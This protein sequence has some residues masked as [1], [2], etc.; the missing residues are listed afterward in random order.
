MSYNRFAYIYDML[1]NH[2]PYE[3]WVNFTNALI[4]QSNKEIK[5]IVD[6]GCGTGE[7]AIRLSDLGYDVTGVD[8][9]TEMLTAAAQK[10]LNR[11]KKISWIKQDIRDLEGF[12]KIDLMVSYCDV[13]NYIT[14]KEDLLDVFKRVHASLT[15]QGM[16]I[17]DIHSIYYAEEKLI[18]HTFA[19][20][21]EDIA[22]IW[23]C[24]QGE[25]RGEMYHYLTFFQK[26]KQHYS[27][28]DETHHQQVYEINVYKDLL[29]AS[30]FS[31]IDIYGDFLIENQFSER[32][33]ERI[34]IC[35]QK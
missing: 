19:D 13:I 35:V 14:E 25:K 17:F 27:R 20:V 32:N 4:H 8:Y 6:L 26:D 18:N 31:K 28:F 2:A 11:N 1:M 34:F 29:K 16:F 9:S 24:E 12:N 15:E 5:S 10:A 21:T 33:S 7:I 23:E 30:G 22:Y 3:Q